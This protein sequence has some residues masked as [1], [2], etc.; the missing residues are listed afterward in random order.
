MNEPI[1][2]KLSSFEDA[3]THLTEKDFE[4]GEEFNPSTPELS[5]S[6]SL[7]RKRPDHEL[8]LVRLSDLAQFGITVDDI[9]DSGMIFNPD[10][11]KWELAE[12]CGSADVDMTGF[13]SSENSSCGWD[14]EFG[15][16]SAEDKKPFPL[17]PGMDKNKGSF[18]FS[19]TARAVNSPTSKVIEDDEISGL[20]NAVSE[21]EGDWD[22]EEEVHPKATQLK[23]SLANHGDDDELDM[24]GFDSDSNVGLETLPSNSNVRRDDGLEDD[25]DNW[26]DDFDDNTTGEARSHLQ[27][28]L[29][30]TLDQGGK[31]ADTA[32]GSKVTAFLKN[33]LPAPST[34]AGP[35]L[36]RPED[37]EG[38]GLL[39]PSAIGRGTVTVSTLSMDS[40]SD[41]PLTSSA[42]SGVAEALSPPTTDMPTSI[43][44][45]S[46]EEVTVP[47]EEEEN[48]DDGFEVG[49]DF[50]FKLTTQSPKVGTVPP[51]IATRGGHHSSMR[52]I[53]PGD[54]VVNIG[55][56]LIGRQS[57]EGEKPLSM[58]FDRGLQK[59][60][61]REGPGEEIDWGSDEEEFDSSSKRSGRSG[62]SS[63][64]CDGASATSERASPVPT[65]GAGG[66]RERESRAEDFVIDRDFALVCERQH[67]KDLLSF[68]GKEE[69]DRLVLGRNAG[70]GAGRPKHMRT[71]SRGRPGSWR[72]KPRQSPSSIGAVHTP[73][74]PLATVTT[75]ADEQRHI[76]L[77][78]HQQTGSRGSVV[79][80]KTT[81]AQEPCAATRIGSRKRRVFQDLWAVYSCDSTL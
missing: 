37:L 10:D 29:P 7:I 30:S 24:S 49:E 60:V 67:Y 43:G 47:Q 73:P 2:L 51:V 36:I 81:P 12:G 45:P 31:S 20:V 8:V 22:E 69:F 68:L 59:W 63:V 58:R 34:G 13:E 38:L 27:L 72:G 44:T 14:Q 40:M 5:S 42:L 64:L 9:H 35:Q 66:G 16:A 23:V 39:K 32:Q 77:Q 74:K 21:S 48:W 15:F 55:A 6:F 80:S 52:V 78:R 65:D 61:E 79:A 57:E 75:T 11:Q 71:G 28:H 17:A 4:F 53:T 25:D 18:I 19:D 70:S 56:E 33:L 62:V 3:D 26:D 46:T 41:G 76:P 50:G 54:V 1:K